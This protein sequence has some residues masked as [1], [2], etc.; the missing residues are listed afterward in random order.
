M[1]NGIVEEFE[2]RP[3]VHY[4]H[5]PH[6]RN[7]NPNKSQ[8]LVGMPEERECFGTAHDKNWIEAH[9]AWG[10]LLQDGE[11]IPLGISADGHFRCKVAKF[12]DGSR[13]AHW[14]GYPADHRKT[15]DSPPVSISRD[16][17]QQ[18]TIG[19]HIVRKLMRA[20]PC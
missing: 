1:A 4:L 17:L 5:H 12:V 7:Q 13:N 9:E 8:W 18:H 3:G 14:H 20:E 15:Q 6:H 16:W 11:P 2:V 19:R 10:F